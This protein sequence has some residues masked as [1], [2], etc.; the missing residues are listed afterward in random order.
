MKFSSLSLKQVIHL[1]DTLSPGFA[2]RFLSIFRYQAIG[3]DVV[4]RI[5]LFKFSCSKFVQIGL[6]MW[7]IVLNFLTELR[8]PKM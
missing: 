1:S 3:F 2:I 6:E 5:L 4:K 8:Y 7:T